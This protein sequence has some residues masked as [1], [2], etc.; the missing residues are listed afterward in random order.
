[1]DS[2]LSYVG[3]KSKLR[4]QLIDLFPPHK[5]YIEGFF[6][7]GWVFFGKE[8]SKYEVINDL[9]D[10][11]I[12]FWRVIKYHL[13]EFIKQ[14]KYILISRTQFKEWQD[15][16]NGPGLTDIQRAAMYYYLQRQCFGGRVNSRS[17]GTAAN[18]YPKVNLLRMEEELSE[19]HLRLANVIIENRTYSQ[20]YGTYDTSDTLFFLD[21][22]YWQAPYYKHNFLNVDDYYEMAKLAQNSKGNTIIT[23]NDHPDIRNAFEG[24]HMLETMVTY[25]VAVGDNAKEYPE[26][27]ISNIPLEPS[28]QKL[29]A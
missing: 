19:V 22:P 23:I 8:Q 14:F 25:T 18:M 9:D 1:M 3:G 10:D 28:Q 12:R 13:E 11:L 5:T 2:P 16:L 20:L 17:F 4:N 24:L 26:L 29:F 6:G 7:A 27:I 15:Q 21:P